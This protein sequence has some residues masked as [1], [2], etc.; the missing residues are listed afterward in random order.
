[1]RDKVKYNAYMR[2][3]R[4]KNPE[5]IRGYKRKAYKYEPRE[6]KDMRHKGAKVTRALVSEVFSSQGK[7]CAI[8]G[9]D[10]PGFVNW[11]ADHNHA[12][13]ELRGVLC[14][15]CNIGL[16]HFGDN[17]HTLMAAATYLLTRGCYGAKVV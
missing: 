17:P 3:W 13:M 9:T 14:H 6:Y 1:M 5:K 16:G 8:C 4:S 10:K 12:S 11:S 2:A 15:R 7:V